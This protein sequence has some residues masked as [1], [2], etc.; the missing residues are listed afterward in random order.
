MSEKIPLYKVPVPSTSFTKEAYYDGEG[1]FPAIRFAYKK[2]GEEHEGQISFSKVT[3]TRKRAERCCTPWHID[4]AYDTLVEIRD[5]S[6]AE[7]IRVDTSPRWRDKW[8]M[9]HY[10][11]YLDSVGCFEVIAES[12]QAT[13]AGGKLAYGIST[14]P[15]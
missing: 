15:R 7:E 10:M 1:A 3:A 14:S 5:S 8:P 9:H 11:I 2:N 13:D 12:W 6:W 4:G